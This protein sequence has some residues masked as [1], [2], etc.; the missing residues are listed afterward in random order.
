ML[1]FYTADA[2]KAIRETIEAGLRQGFFNQTQSAEEKLCGNKISLWIRPSQ[3]NTPFS[4]ITS[5]N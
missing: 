3:M 1:E 4:S 5:Y 2:S